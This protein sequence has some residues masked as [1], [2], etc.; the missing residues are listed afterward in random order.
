M[1]MMMIMVYMIY[2]ADGRRG[3]RGRQTRRGV[4]VRIV[5]VRLN[6]RMGGCI[7][8]W[9]VYVYICACVYA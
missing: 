7:Y 8:V 6:A 1:M 5:Y 3:G 2:G 4:C 9:N